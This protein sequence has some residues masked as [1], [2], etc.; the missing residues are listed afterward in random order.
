MARG[1]AATASVVRTRSA[2]GRLGG[3]APDT[4]NAHRMPGVT[5]R[6]M[7]GGATT[8][9]PALQRASRARRDDRKRGGPA[10]QRHELARSIR[11]LMNEHH[12]R[13]TKVPRQSTKHTQDGLET[14]GRGNK[15]DHRHAI[16]Q[17]ATG[18]DFHDGT[19]WTRVSGDP[20][21]YRNHGRHR[22]RQHLDD[23]VP[24]TTDKHD[25]RRRRLP[26]AR[27]S[28]A[29]PHIDATPP[30]AVLRPTPNGERAHDEH[31]PAES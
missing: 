3:A 27:V 25:R 5:S 23:H 10:E 28:G 6:C 24:S 4:I 21:S 9:R 14:A 13:R 7:P 17:R 8:T 1:P 2:D 16:T 29:T 20:R 19:L 22:S 15:R 30:D 18:R 12:D 31:A 26:Q 11:R